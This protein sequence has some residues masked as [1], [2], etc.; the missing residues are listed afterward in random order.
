[1]KRI[2]IL[3][4][5]GEG[6][7]FGHFS[8]CSPIALILSKT[9]QVE[10]FV[11][12]KGESEYNLNLS[13]KIK[14]TVIDWKESISE[15]VKAEDTVIIDSYLAQKKHFDQIASISKK[16]LVFDDYYRLEYNCRLILNPNVSA[17]IDKYS[18]KSKNDLI[19]GSDYIIVRNAFQNL[20]L[21]ELNETVKEVSITVGGSDYRKLLPKFVKLFAEKYPAI[22]FHV[23]TGNS[24]LKQKMEQ[25]Y[26]RNNFNFYGLLNQ[27]EMAAIFMESDLAIS[28]SGQTLGELVMTQTPFV[29]FCIDKDQQPIRTFYL[30]QKI[31]DNKIEWDD[32]NFEEK[33]LNSFEG[34][35]NLE[36]RQQFIDKSRNI[37][38]GNG[39]NRICER[40][41]ELANG[42]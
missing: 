21:G 20:V 13:P 5:L 23:L 32:V 4:E 2:L 9:C 34:L 7:G 22:N 25:E 42:I 14:T 11:Y 19:A 39:V 3:T 18:Y 24:Q 8:R 38:D 16:S 29:A 31:I 6:I 26:S 37:I 12:Q 17:D 27:D 40:I 41:K 36:K 28:A 15:I 1:M 35:L 33:I 10:I 30:E